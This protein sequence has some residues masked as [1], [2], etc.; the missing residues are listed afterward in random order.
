MNLNEA[1]LEVVMEMSALFYSPKEIAVALEVDPDAF[2]TEVRSECGDIYRT[3][4]KGYLEGDIGLRKSVMESALHGSSPAQAMMR[5][6]Q[7]SGKIAA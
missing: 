1:E 3:Y 5:E 7:K 6:I 4:M 2:I